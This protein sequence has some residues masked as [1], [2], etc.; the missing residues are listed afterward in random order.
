MI[1]CAA[2]RIAMGKHSSLGPIDPQLIVP[3]QSVMMAHPAQAILDQFELAKEE[4]KDP[5]LLG[6]W[7]PILPQYGP[8]LLVQCINALDLAE[9]L[10]AEPIHRDAARELGLRIEKLEDDQQF[11]DLVLTVYHATT[12]TFSSTAAAKIIENHLGRAFIKMHLV[13]NVQFQFA[14]PPG[15]APAPPTAAPQGTPDAPPS[16]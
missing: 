10:V 16:G 14:P 7:M 2:N 1:A 3:T 11:Q 4:C 5:Q 15:P 12:H 8:A 13:Q 6:A 9:D